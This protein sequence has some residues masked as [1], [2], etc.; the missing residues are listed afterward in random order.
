MASKIIFVNDSFEEFINW[1][2]VNKSN[3]KK[4]VELIKHIQRSPFEGIGKPEALKHHL[5]GCWSRRITDEHRLI[6]RINTEAEVE[7]VSCKGHYEN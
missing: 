5:K 2:I 6:Y 3:F 4:I 1:S 7:I